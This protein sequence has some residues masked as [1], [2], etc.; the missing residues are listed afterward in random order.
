M[1]RGLSRSVTLIA[2]GLAAVG[3]SVPASADATKV[4]SSLD[5]AVNDVKDAAA[6]VHEVT[7]YWTPERMRAAVPMDSLVAVS[8]AEAGGTA[9]AEAESLADV[10]SGVERMVPGVS[11]Q[12]FPT[13][14]EPWSGGGEVADTAGRVFFTFNG[15]PASCSGNAVTSDNRS[16]VIT[17]GHCV[18][19]QGSWHTDWIFVPG[20][21]NGQAPHG[22]WVARQT[23]TTPQWEQSEDMNYDIGAAVVEPLGGAYLTDV[24]G[25]QGIAF[26]QQRDQDMYAFGY[27]AAAPYDGSTLIHCSG[28]TFTDFLLTD[29]HAMSCDMTGGSSGGPW[30]LNFDESTGTGVQASVNSFGYTFLPGYMFGPYFGSDAE[31][32]YDAAAAA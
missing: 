24:V 1:K 16:V 4:S 27:P 15:N 17:A 32:L 3:L 20:Y 31:A 22:E 26:N 12:A 6:T 5:V 10:A 21:D 13:S 23:L 14:G 9:V 30:F 19:Y 8:A 7:D 28:S 18:K 25:A 2:A 11:P 29:D